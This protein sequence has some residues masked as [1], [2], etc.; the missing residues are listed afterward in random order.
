MES[1]RR[2]PNST[3]PRLVVALALSAI[4]ACTQSSQPTDRAI[5][6]D[7]V[8]GDASSDATTDDVATSDAVDDAL[9]AG[10]GREASSI[11]CGANVG[12]SCPCVPPD[13]SCGGL[14][15]TQYYG[16]SVTDWICCWCE[17]PDE[18]PD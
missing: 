17:G 1:V 8:A 18:G 10:G 11:T 16:C 13:A 3:S 7:A 5:G 12:L 14:G 2:H 6:P 9:D 15:R 4:T